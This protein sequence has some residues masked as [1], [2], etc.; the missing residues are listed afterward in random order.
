MPLAL[1][2][3]KHNATVS[4]CHSKTTNIEDYVKQADIF[5]SAIGIPT[6]FKGEWFKEGCIAID[7]GINE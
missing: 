6:Y 3:N 7:V 2:L 5:I 1:L 4:I